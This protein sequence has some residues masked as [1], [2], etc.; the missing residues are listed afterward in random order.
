MPTLCAMKFRIA[1]VRYYEADSEALKSEFPEE[2]RDFL[3]RN[4]FGDERAW[5]W[6]CMASG[7]LS[8]FKFVDSEIEFD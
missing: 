1:E 7:G 5:V 6:D 4:K 2:Y 3:E 8:L